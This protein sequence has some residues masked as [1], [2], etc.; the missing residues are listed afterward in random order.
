[1]SEY[2]PFT[3]IEMWKGH[4]DCYIDKLEDKLYTSND[5]DIGYFVGI[6]LKNPD[7]IK[8]KTKT[9]KNCVE[10]KVSPQDKFNKHMKVIKVVI[11]TPNK[12]LT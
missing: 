3:E 11:Y 1:M 12:E 8:E 7:A 10:K 6:D 9:F 5:S 4:P 2:L